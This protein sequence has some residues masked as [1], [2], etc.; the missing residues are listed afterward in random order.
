MPATPRRTKRIS[1]TDRTLFQLPDGTGGTITGGPMRPLDLME[2]LTRD[3]DNLTQKDIAVSGA[4]RIIDSVSLKA[5][6][7]GAGI[8]LSDGSRIVFRSVEN[9][10][11]LLD[12]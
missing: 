3:R 7:S 8:A 6:S 5:Q 10:D 12:A 11:I 9:G 4:A 2:L 1:G